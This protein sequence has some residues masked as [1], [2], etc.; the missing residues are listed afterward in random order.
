[1]PQSANRPTIGL[2]LGGGGARGLAHIGVLKALERANIAVDVLAGTSMG[3]LIAAFYAA[4]RS[5]TEIEAEAQQLGKLSQLLNL[6]DLGLPHRAF[7][8][9]EKFYAFLKDKL[10]PLLT[11]AE[12]GRPLALTAVDLI[13]GKEVILREGLVAEA[14]RATIAL[15]SVIEPVKRNGQLLVDGGVLNNIP[16]GQARALGADVVIAVNVSLD[17]HDDRLWQKVGLPAILVDSW[18]ADAISAAALTDIRL[19]LARPEVILR[20]PTPSDITTLTGFTRA[21]EIIAAGEAAVEEALP[22]LREVARAR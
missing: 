18:R 1:M 20:P 4:G 19:A 22:K 12:L 14:V 6:V 8:S 13:S 21:S 11:F 9:G 3:G 15:P 7:L 5:A 16:A 10:G 2:A 17:V